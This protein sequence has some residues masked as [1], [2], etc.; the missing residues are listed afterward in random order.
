MLS[1]FV[2]RALVKLL[3]F[4]TF[5]FNLFKPNELAYP[6]HEDKLISY[7]KGCWVVFFIFSES[8]IEHSVSKQWR[9]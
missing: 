9:P 8:L 1:R 7:L 4:M 3:K 6:Y 5:L 2:D